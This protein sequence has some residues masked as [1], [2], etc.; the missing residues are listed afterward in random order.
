MRAVARW[1]LLDALR[2]LAAL[3]VVFWHWPHFW[4]GD[5]LASRLSP[6]ALPL[7]PILAP[8][9]AYGWIA[10]DMFFVLSGF[11]FFWKYAA[12]I[13][14]RRIGVGQFALL[15]F[16][17]LYPLHLLA[18]VLVAILQAAYSARFG[19][20]FVFANNDAYHLLLNLVMAE[21]WGLEQG[22]SFD[23]PAWSVSIEILLYAIF[24]LAA[25][26]RLAGTWQI[27]VICIAATLAYPA[28]EAILVRGIMDFFAGGLAF[29]LVDATASVRPAARYAGGVGVLL[30]GAF[31]MIARVAYEPDFIRAATLL[32]FPSLVYLL[33][34]SETRISSG[35]LQWLGDLSYSS[36]LLHFP[37]QLLASYAVLAIAGPDGVTL[38]S[39]AWTLL[40]FFA[41][42]VAVSLASNRLIE[43][44]AQKFILKLRRPRLPAQIAT[45]I[46][47]K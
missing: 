24:F 16:A 1:T 14:E 10:V 45:K 40:A 20:A 8:L 29:R 4:S 37:L 28:Q 42:L 11:V 35:R 38:F 5:Q 27:A 30:T 2:G 31:L 13:G 43:R 12:A 44:P 18:L 26:A 36:Y 17:R 21:A 39:R 6:D 25:S 9:Y 15:R 19:S 22:F 32:T 47:T 33:A 41:V 34:I 7:Y 3:T 23:G 46:V